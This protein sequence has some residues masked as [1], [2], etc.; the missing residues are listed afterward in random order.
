[1]YTSLVDYL[2]SYYK[3]GSFAAICISNYK[4]Y[5]CKIRVGRFTVAE[6]TVIKLHCKIYSG[7][8]VAF[9][10]DSE[11]IHFLF[12]VIVYNIGPWSDR[13]SGEKQIPT[14]SG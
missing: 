8:N 6:I 5:S 11:K 9:S 1:M 14:N 10:P 13:F 3:N 12:A 4:N 2:H 7:R